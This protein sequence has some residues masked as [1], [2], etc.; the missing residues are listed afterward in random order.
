MRTIH[1][2][3]A[4]LMIATNLGVAGYGFFVVRKNPQ[5]LARL[6]KLFLVGVGMVAVQ[7]V[8]GVILLNQLNASAGFHAFYGF[9]VLI[10][11]VLAFEFKKDE[12]N[13]RILVL[14]A[15]ALFIGAVSIRGWTTAG[16]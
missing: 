3:W 11:G 1:T 4:A 12:P 14:S 13:K 10:A 15:V 2:I 5:L 8:L 7:V 9:V 16:R 6:Q